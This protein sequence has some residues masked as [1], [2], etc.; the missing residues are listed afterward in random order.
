MKPDERTKVLKWY[1][2]QV[3]EK[4]FLISKKKLSNIADQML[5]SSLSVEKTLSVWKTSILS[6]TSQSLVFA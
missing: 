6:V 1:D 2:A 5:T 3:N 4:Y